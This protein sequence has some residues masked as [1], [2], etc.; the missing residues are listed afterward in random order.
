MI[1]RFLSLTCYNCT[2]FGDS[3]AR[4]AITGIPGRVAH[5]IIP[6]GMDHQR[7]PA[8]GKHGIG[9]IAERNGR[10]RNRQFGRTV[11]FHGEIRHI[12][13]VRLGAHGVV[14]AVVRVSRVEMAPCAGECGSFA[15]RGSVDVK[16]VLAGRQAI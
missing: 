6:F 3:P 2:L 8:I 13:R 5:Q 7:R 12:A 15:F 11:R 14:D 1:V 4:N 16:S 9:S 10:I